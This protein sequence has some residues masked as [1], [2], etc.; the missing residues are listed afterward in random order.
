MKT[1]V[2]FLDTKTI[3]LIIIYR[4]NE[5]ETFILYKNSCTIITKKSTKN[6][7]LILVKVKKRK[8]KRTKFYIVLILHRQIGTS[9]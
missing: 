4:R 5:N 9:W 3:I 7:F 8:R 6:F 1:L 2:I